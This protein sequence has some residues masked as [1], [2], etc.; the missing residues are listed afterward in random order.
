VKTALRLL[1]AAW[2]LAASACGPVTE[3]GNPGCTVYSEGPCT[4]TGN[5]SVTGIVRDPSGAPAPGADVRL[6][7]LPGP[8]LHDSTALAAPVLAR[9][10]KAGADGSFRF[11][12]LPAAEY[13]LEGADSARD[14]YALDA[15]LDLPDSGT[16]VKADLDLKPPGRVEGAA[17]RGP[18][19]RPAGVAADENILVRLAGTGRYAFTAASGDY[20]LAKVPEGLYLAA[21]AAADGHYLPAYVDSVRV[22]AGEVTRLPLV[23]LQ[24]S[25]FAAPPA[26]AGLSVAIDSASGTAALRWHAVELD[27]FLHYEVVRKSGGD[28]LVFIV[29]DTLL[30]DSLRGLSAGRPLEYRVRTVNSLGNK[31]P[32]SSAHAA[33]TVPGPPPQGNPS[34][35][36]GRV[37]T[38][39]GAAAANAV[40]VLYSV[41]AGPGPADSL[42]VPARA[43]DTAAADSAGRFAFRKLPPGAYGVEARDAV[44]GTRAMATG[45]LLPRDA[46]SAVNLSLRV[47]GALRGVASRQH[48]WCST[49]HKG[50]EGILVS[51]AGTPYGTDTRNVEG[52]FLIDSVP[53]GKYRL[54]IAAPPLGCFLPDTLDVEIRAGDTV[55]AGVITAPYNTDLVPMAANL[56]I[57]SASGASVALQWDR[58]SLAYPDLA[59]YRVFRRD[60][61]LRVLFASP[62]GASTSFTDDLSAVPKGTRLN[63]VVQTVAKDGKVSRFAG[64]HAGNPVTYVVP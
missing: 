30:V 52:D 11:D 31:S 44:T 1:A 57:A 38:A 58:V 19:A 4:E 26:P 20:S 53:A 17:T 27:N 33:A 14:L 32:D 6:Y 40:V 54:V 60:D 56:R 5:P 34:A 35:L 24:W 39:Q 12:S 3:Q 22:K 13:S 46:A 8:P 50:N 64:D 37:A 48:L 23:R 42:P 18:D 15:R 61:S 36:Q 9:S 47:T 55:Q 49:Y 28:S 63:Y 51:L 45:L 41:P 21:F 2:L 25:P 16:H 29:T 59:G 62:V 7:R 10:I 43:V